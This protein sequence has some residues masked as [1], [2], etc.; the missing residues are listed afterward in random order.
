[1]D[2]EVTF[3]ESMLER[4]NSHLML[5]STSAIVVAEAEELALRLLENAFFM[6]GNRFPRNGLG[7]VEGDVN[8]GRISSSKG[9]IE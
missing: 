6:F 5:G 7:D 8:A 3:G 1:M 2:A 4:S 9:V